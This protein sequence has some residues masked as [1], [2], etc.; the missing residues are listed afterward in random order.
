M[1][2]QFHSQIFPLNLPLQLWMF[3]V[4]HLQEH[5]HRPEGV[6]Y[7]QL[8]YCVKG[9][10][11][12]MLNERRS[13]ISEGQGFLI[14]PDL[15]HTYQG[16]TPDWTLHIVAFQGAICKEVLSSLQIGESGAY[17]FSDSTVFE[18]H[19]QNLLWLHENRSM[20]RS[21]YYSKECYSFLLDVSQCMTHI[22]DY[23]YAQENSLVLN[24]VTY[25]E[26]NYSS[27]IS[28]DTLAALVNLSKDYMCVRF[29]AATGQTIIHC[30]TS[31]RMG[32]A[33]QFL[34]QY[35]E[36]R[37][38]DIARMCGFESPSYF[39]KIFKKLLGV[40]PEKYRKKGT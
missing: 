10:G 2:Y 20:N 18:K 37:V 16:I 26:A 23:S 5:I 6:P 31:I 28:L 15:S 4:H 19:I 38:V 7:F 13:I 12:L 3:G 36:T 29:K 21:L 33:R 32:H 25:L 34:M 14:Y 40:S 22:Y 9:Q 24:I 11:E 27:P 17:H 30:L 1:L 8:F 39:G 35:P